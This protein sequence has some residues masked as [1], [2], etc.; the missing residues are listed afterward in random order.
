LL[1]TDAGEPV[2]PVRHTDFS[3]GPRLAMLRRQRLPFTSSSYGTA[4][5]PQNCCRTA[6]TVCVIIERITDTWQWEPVQR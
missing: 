3:V 5:V 2:I 4:E 6:A 1:A